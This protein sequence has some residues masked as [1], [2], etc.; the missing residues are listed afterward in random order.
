[1]KQNAIIEAIQYWLEKTVIG[2]N[3]CPFAK[4][5]F[6]K[7]SIRYVVC[8]EQDLAMQLE[9]FAKEVE[10]LDQNPACET[11]LIIF[12]NSLTDFNDYLD[13]LDRASDLLDQLGYSGV[14]QLASFHPDYCFADVDINDPSN[15]TNRSPLPIFHLI[16]EA[17]ISRVLASVTQPELIPQANIDLAKEKGT[18]TFQNILN[19]CQ[20]LMEKT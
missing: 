8:D 2:F 15:Y 1:M 9:L 16:R 13:Q 6:I 14:Y 20:Q 7:Q 18:G 4:K 12:S 11:S 19:H 10:F 17:S 5:E 3:F